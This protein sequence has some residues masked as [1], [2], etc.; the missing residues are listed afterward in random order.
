M[1]VLTASFLLA[2][3]AEPANVASEG[4][5][6]LGVSPGRVLLPASFLSLLTPIACSCGQSSILTT[7]TCDS[8]RVLFQKA[9]FGCSFV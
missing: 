4:G 2:S 5:M 3:D 1:T 6:V 7:V 9:F 8:Y